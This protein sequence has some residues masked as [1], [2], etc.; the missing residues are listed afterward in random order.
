MNMFSDFT[1]RDGVPLQGPK[2]IKIT[3]T[4]K[5]VRPSS[6]ESCWRIKFAHSIVLPFIKKLFTGFG[7]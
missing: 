7:S 3:F 5:P 4:N 6:F 1:V 2:V